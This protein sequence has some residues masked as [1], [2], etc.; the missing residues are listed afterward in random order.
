MIY[1]GSMV[2]VGTAIKVATIKVIG[3]VEVKENSLN[4]LRFNNVITFLT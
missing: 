3:K 4:N 1:I 2:F